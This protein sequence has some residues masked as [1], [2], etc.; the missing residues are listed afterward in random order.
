MEIIEIMKELDDMLHSK[1]IVKIDD[2]LNPTFK[3]L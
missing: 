1:D 3:K 2:N